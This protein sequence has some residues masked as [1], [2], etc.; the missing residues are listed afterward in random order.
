MSLVEKIL[1]RF[2]KDA[3]KQGHII[4]V[5]PHYCMTHDN[6]GA[7]INKY[8]G[9]DNPAKKIYNP[10]QLVFT[11]D[12]DVQNPNN[13]QKYA[14]IEQF[15]K[16]NKID[17]YPAGRGI[18]H[19]IM[20]EEGY[21]LP[22]TLTVA[23][24]SHSNMYGGIGALGTPIVRSDAL[25]IWCTGQ[26]WLKVPEIIKVNLRNSL[27]KGVSGKDLII[28][29]CGY[30]NKDQVLNSFIEFSHSTLSVDDRLTVAN[31]TTEWGALAGVFPYDD[32]AKDYLIKLSKKS[33]R[34]TRSMINDI[35]MLESDGNAFYTKTLDV[36]LSSLTPFVSGPNSVKVYNSLSKVQE[37]KIKINKAYLVSCVNSRAS[38]IEKAAFVLKRKK[39]AKGVEF[40]ISPASSKVLEE[41]EAAGHWQTLLDAGCKPL[42]SGCGPCIGL[43]TGI[44][45]KGEVGISATNRNFKGRM[46]DPSSS[47]YLASP[48]IVAYS[49]R[50]GTIS[51]PKH[52]RDRAVD[53]S[54]TTHSQPQPEVTTTQLGEAVEG[55]L[56]FCGHEN[57]VNTD[58]IY[59]G[60][61]TYQDNITPEQMRDIVMENY[62]P[63]FASLMKSIDKTKI[64]VCGFNFGTGSS[65]EQA[66]T[67]LLACGIK[68]VIAGSFSETF[69]RNALNNG[70]LPLECPKLV[71]ELQESAPYQPTSVLDTITYY[72]GGSIEYNSQKYPCM[73]LKGI[74]KELIKLGGIMPFI[75]K[76]L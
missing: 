5:K 1:Q 38:D 25:S 18:G 27:C 10:N 35:P 17:F 12:H 33:S 44:L 50:T 30:F 73:P 60:K 28:A 57:N 75:S 26:T 7:V 45:G 66:A 36:D 4:S 39:V 59:P 72:D 11:L 63:G 76:S 67:A 52:F 48:E 69:K 58:G 32:M 9:L 55:Q 68:I 54:I 40:Y 19:Q 43:G 70:L 6:S 22:N 15:A 14:G 65:R 74:A 41:A 42:L 20:I 34:L 37:S 64:L 2:S 13:K 71:I 47:C 46:G 21:A 23:S 31:M 16:Q 29:L 62:D 3:V 8:N 61:Y 24:D 49:A 51:G 53:A 56:I